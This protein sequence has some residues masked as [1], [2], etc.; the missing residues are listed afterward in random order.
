LRDFHLSAA[1]SFSTIFLRPSCAQRGA[2]RGRGARPFLAFSR[3]VPLD[4]ATLS[5]E[6]SVLRVLS[7]GVFV[8]PPP[9]WLPRLQPP[10]CRT[11]QPLA[12]SSYR[13]IYNG[14]AAR[15]DVARLSFGRAP[16][17]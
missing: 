13:N 2:Q 10:A 3:Y 14:I 11:T 12:R 8:G 5:G 6:S 9:P 15:P 1:A 4:I 17:K 7:H 16:A